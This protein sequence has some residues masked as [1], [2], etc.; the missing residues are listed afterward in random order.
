[1]DKQEKL[2]DC[3]FR[4]QKSAC[5][6]IITGNNNVQSALHLPKYYVIAYSQKQYSLTPR[7]LRN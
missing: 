3:G 7:T 1:M 4:R 6:S 2:R 5:E